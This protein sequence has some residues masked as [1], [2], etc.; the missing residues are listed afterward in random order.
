LSESFAVVYDT[1]MKRG[2]QPRPTG[3]AFLLSQLGEHVS[4]RFADRVRELGLSPVEVGLL[5]MI[6]G[7]PGRSQR[8]VA[9]DLGVVP[10][11]V[12]VLIDGLDHKGLVERRPGTTD[13]RHHELHLTVDGE[14]IMVD[15]RSIASAHDDE[16]LAALDPEERVAFTRLLQ[17]IADQQGLTPG[18]HSAHGPAG[19]RR[20][21]VGQN[22]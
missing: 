1:H 6:A 12:V 7:Q 19:G 15:M 21:P 14:R 4:E 20:K 16:V 13:R 17:R 3:T 5:R 8:S 22:T 9:V 2:R 18:A 11:R 10:S